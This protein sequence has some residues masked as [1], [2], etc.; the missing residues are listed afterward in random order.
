MYLGR[1][2]ALV[3]YSSTFTSHPA[4][5]RTLQKHPHDKRGLQKS[6]AEAGLAFVIGL[7]EAPVATQFSDSVRGSLLSLPA[8]S[9]ILEPME[10]QV[11]S[12]FMHTT[13]RLDIAALLFSSFTPL[14]QR[15]HRQIHIYTHT[16]TGGETSTSTCWRNSKIP[17]MPCGMTGP[18]IQKKPHRSCIKRC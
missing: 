4:F 12:R 1:H 9:S 18:V 6:W 8:T 14:Y 15:K 11:E 13:S 5:P 3:P 17:N 7:F 2:S 10:E 16:H